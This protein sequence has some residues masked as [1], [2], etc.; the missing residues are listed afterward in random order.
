[1][2]MY[3]TCK[4]NAPLGMMPLAVQK[5]TTSMPRQEQRPQ[6]RP[7]SRVVGGM[8]VTCK[9]SSP[10]GVVPNGVKKQMISAKA[11]NK[12]R[13]TIKKQTRRVHPL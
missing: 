11:K 10:F 7:T 8:Y 2:T 6:K 3:A 9:L 4:A 12:E 13:N 5:S 1:M